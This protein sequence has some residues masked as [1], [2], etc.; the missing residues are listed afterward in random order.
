MNPKK[1]DK[2][3]LDMCN[4]VSERSSC[5]RRQVGAVIVRN[6][7]IISTGVNGTAKGLLNCDQGGCHLANKG[8]LSGCDLEKGMCCHAEENAI[9]QAAYEGVSTKG[10]TLYCNLL[11][12]FLC[13]KMIINSGIKRVVYRQDYSDKTSSLMFKEARISLRRIK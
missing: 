1:E 11:P 8:R 2:W 9:V 5:T 3:F 7:H 13:A 6:S 4:V 10:A 12:C